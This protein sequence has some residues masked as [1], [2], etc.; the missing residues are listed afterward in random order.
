[1]IA[2]L[3]SRKNPVLLRSTDNERQRQVA[4]GGAE[5]RDDGGHDENRAVKYPTSTST[6]NP[7]HSLDVHHQPTDNRNLYTDVLAALDKEFWESLDPE[8]ELPGDVDTEPY[9]LQ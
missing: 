6:S 2:C 9:Q 1:M 7:P 3:Y 5:R 4:V 8:C